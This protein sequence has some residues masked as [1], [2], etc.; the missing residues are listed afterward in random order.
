M[1]LFEVTSNTAAGLV[2]FIEQKEYYIAEKMEWRTQAAAPIQ[3]R[4]KFMKRGSHSLTK[5]DLSGLLALK[6]LQ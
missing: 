1:E 4:T 6:D 5:V 2:D 3:E